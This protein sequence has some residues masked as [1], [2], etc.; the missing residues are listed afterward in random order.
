MESSEASSVR[1]YLGLVVYTYLCE[2]VICVSCPDGGSTTL[3]FHQLGAPCW[4]TLHDFQA[5]RTSPRH[6]R[7]ASSTKTD[8]LLYHLQTR[9]KEK[10]QQM[11]LRLLPETEFTSTWV[12]DMLC[13]FTTAHF[14]C[15][16]HS[17]CSA[18]LSNFQKPFMSKLERHLWLNMIAV[19][20]HIIW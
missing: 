14:L 6:L 7:A 5:C 11:R 10:M 1:L 12:V 19:I 13:L 3:G 4:T 16:L 20:Y 8:Q 18:I 15:M 9:C 17:W 2:L